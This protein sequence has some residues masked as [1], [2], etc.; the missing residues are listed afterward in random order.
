MHEVEKFANTG[1]LTRERARRGHNRRTLLCIIIATSHAR[2]YDEQTKDAPPGG[3]E[4]EREARPV[5]KKAPGSS[6]G[7]TPGL[8]GK[9]PPLLRGTAVT[10]LE[11]GNKKK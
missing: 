11:N 7:A 9:S 10:S 2:P 8:A 5:D 6:L 1:P 4:L 3:E